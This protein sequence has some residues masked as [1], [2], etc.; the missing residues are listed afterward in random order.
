MHYNSAKANDS[1]QKEKRKVL[2]QNA[3]PAETILW[4]FLRNRGVGDIS[5]VVNKA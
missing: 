3:T 1:V 2:R 4:H 5:F